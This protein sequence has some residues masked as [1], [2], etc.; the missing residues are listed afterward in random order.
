[1]E[2]IKRIALVAHDN[3][4][5]DLIEWIEW[6]WEVLQHHH[7]IC[8]GTT[9]KL[10]EEAL[11]KK[12]SEQKKTSI[13][14]QKLKS[15]P[16]GGDQ[17]LGAL[18]TEG[19]VDIIVFFWDPMQPQPHDVDV[20]ALLRITVLYNVPTAC[21]RSTADFIISSPLF[22]ESYNPK[23]KDYSEYIFRKLGDG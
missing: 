2:K 3:R 19:Q 10:V 7:L 13:H 9:G 20:K 11:L 21:N 16:L 22:K 6:N 4:K 18:I 12:V 17:Q 5:T 1:M 14:I 23:I 15:G 8:T